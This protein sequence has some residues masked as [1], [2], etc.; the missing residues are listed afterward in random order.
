[1]RIRSCRSPQPSHRR[2]PNPEYRPAGQVLVIFAIALLVLI[3]FIGL[4]IDA[5][6]IYVSYGQLKR[7]V[8]AASLAAANTFKRGE[9]VENMQAA[10]EEVLALHNVDMSEV[11]LSVY[12]CDMD[13]DAVRDP[14][15]ETEVP[16]FYHI[17]PKT[18]QGEAPRKLVWV[19]AAQR[20]PFYFLGLLGFGPMLLTTDATSEAA[21]IDLVLV[22]D[23]SESMASETPGYV[24][25]DYDPDGA[26]G[27]NPLTRTPP[28]AG[29]ENP[30]PPSG[31]CL[32]FWHAKYAAYNLLEKLYDGY[33]QVSIIT[34]D[35]RAVIHPIANRRGVTVSLTDDLQAA[36][37]YIWSSINVHD[38]PPVRRM[39]QQWI[40]NR[41][42]NPVN[43][44]DRDGDGRDYDDPAVLGYTCP[45]MNDPRM[46]DRWW[47]YNP[48][49]DP[50]KDIPGA[51]VDPHGWGGVPCDD[52]NLL[53]AYDWDGDGVFTMAD[54]QA[55]LDYLNKFPTVTVGGAAVRPSLSP[56]STCI[57]CGLRA[58]NTVLQNARPGAVWVVVLLTDGVANLSDTYGGGSAPGDTPWSGASSEM[59]SSSYP[60]GFC[61]GQ[62]NGGF[63]PRLCIDTTFTPRYCVD[64]HPLTCPPNTTYQ[65]HPQQFNY[66]VSD[67]AR[68]MID[69]LALT[70]SE[71]SNEPRG[72]D[73]A[74]YSIGLGAVGL[75]EPLLRY[76]AAVGMDGD[77]TTDPCRN[78]APFRSCG[79]YYYTS[80]AS[81]LVE[82]FEDIATRIYTRLT[83]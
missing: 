22:I 23:V 37:A 56:L 63:W 31:A 21:P 48:G 28:P 9:G 52:D 27:C 80:E 12:I 66:S 24:P 64:Q 58:A 36:R 55:S 72:N 25:D 41:A 82:I 32:P 38:D 81:Q 8:D 57:G 34:Y 16:R 4:A 39:W 2:R 14:Y 40:D 73:V 11:N 79:H 33:D 5:G 35:S 17:C 69:A 71:N 26:G 46:A 68:D 75:G 47:D 70:R 60:N 43:P 20:A 29:V 65:S 67:Y 15:L 45:P 54:H 18:E 1:M 3:F 42:V 77:R 51:P 19:Q 74:V 7:A 6:S 50:N 59:V 53:D 30:D 13:G 78:T 61:N 49:N 44:E 62:L 83:H 10:A 76:I